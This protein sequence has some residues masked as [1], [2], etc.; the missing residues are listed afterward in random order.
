M[1]FGNNI[2]SEPMSFIFSLSSLIKSSIQNMSLISWW[3]IYNELYYVLNYWCLVKSGYLTFYWRKWIPFQLFQ[4]LWNQVCGKQQ[5]NFVLSQWMTHFPSSPGSFSF[6]ISD[7][8]VENCYLAVRFEISVLG[9]GRQGKV[10]LWII[11]TAELQGSANKLRLK[12]VQ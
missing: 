11:E 12:V 9:F 8:S 10:T 5:R 2:L 4:S 1:L 6:L 3:S 7:W